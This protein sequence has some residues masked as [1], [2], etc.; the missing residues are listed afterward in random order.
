MTQVLRLWRKKRFEKQEN[1]R[2]AREIE[3][4]SYLSRLVREDRERQ[5]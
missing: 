5:V 2:L 3:L 4:Q 1:K